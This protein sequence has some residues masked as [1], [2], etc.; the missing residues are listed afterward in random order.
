MSSQTKFLATPLVAKHCRRPAVWM[1]RVCEHRKCE[2]KTQRKLNYHTSFMI[3]QSRWFIEFVKCNYL[4]AKDYSMARNRERKQQQSTHSVWLYMSPLAP[5]PCGRGGGTC[6]HFYKWLGTPK[7][8]IVL[9]EPKKWRGAT[10]K[11]F[12]LFVP[13]RCPHFQ[14]RSGATACRHHSEK[15]SINIVSD[16]EN[17]R[18]YV[19]IHWVK[20]SQN[21]HLAL[22]SGYGNA[23]CFYF[24]YC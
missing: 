3:H 4:R 18:K 1:P 2:E 12:R 13:D 19:S 9:L 16:S 17:I 21:D 8:L 6:P 11:N 5:T 24:L 15:A 14:I 23:C 22:I 7:R 10:P 20:T